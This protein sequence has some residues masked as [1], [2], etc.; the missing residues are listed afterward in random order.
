MDL[1]VSAWRSEHNGA[2][3]HFFLCVDSTPVGYMCVTDV[4]RNGVSGAGM[5]EAMEVR[6]IFRGYG[7]A[8]ETAS[9]VGNF[10]PGGLFHTGEFTRCGNARASHLFPALDDNART[11]IVDRGMDDNVVGINTFVRDWENME[12]VFA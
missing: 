10:Y 7:Y 9:A 8:R 12:P 1:T 4:E 6:D 5:V 3:R 11:V 2:R